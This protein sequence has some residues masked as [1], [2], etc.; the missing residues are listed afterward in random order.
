MDEG[1][2]WFCQNQVHKEELIGDTVEA[3]IEEDVDADE[4][5][6]DADE[7]ETPIR[8]C[9]TRECL[10]RR[11]VLMCHYRA[12]EGRDHHELCAI[13]LHTGREAS[14]TVVRHRV[15]KKRSV[16]AVAVVR[17]DEVVEDEIRCRQTCRGLRRT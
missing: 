15:T 6:S 7:H 13:V 16:C 11:H 8:A 9:Q 3:D 4:D 5:V 1:I 12:C 2:L 10:Q 14:V 17:V